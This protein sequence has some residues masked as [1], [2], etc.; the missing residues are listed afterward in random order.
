ME[1]RQHLAR[2]TP[3]S[4]RRGRLVIN[5]LSFLEETPVERWDLLSSRTS[6]SLGEPKSW[7][8]HWHLWWL[9]QGTPQLPPSTPHPTCLWSW[10]GTSQWHREE[11]L[12]CVEEVQGE[13]K[14]QFL[15]P[16]RGVRIR[17]GQPCGVLKCLLPPTHHHWRVTQLEQLSL[18]HSQ[19][20]EAWS[21]LSRQGCRK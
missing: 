1:I 3:G 2:F 14:S 12:P 15:F 8:Q 4:P 21:Q 9:W 11:Q 18:E 17:Q 19:C 5:D 10:Q 13:G 7:E 16:G 6:P 20:G